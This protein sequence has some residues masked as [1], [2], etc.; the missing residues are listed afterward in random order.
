ME[1]DS[2]T[3][4]TMANALNERNLTS[5]EGKKRFRKH[6]DEIKETG[7]ILWEIRED[8]FFEPTPKED[9]YLT[10]GPLKCP[11]CEKTDKFRLHC[12]GLFDVVV[13][14]GKEDRVEVVNVYKIEEVSCD[15]CQCTDS[16]ETFR[17]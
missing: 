17:T 4:F 12:E 9:G 6:L 10:K 11:N 7:W 1:L 2:R 5:D 3:I 16:L 13:K 15:N 8:A 14:T